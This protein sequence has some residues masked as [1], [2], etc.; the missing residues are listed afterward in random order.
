MAK[1][2]TEDSI[3]LFLEARHIESFTDALEAASPR[4]IESAAQAE[5]KNYAERFSKALSVGIAQ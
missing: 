5:K 1:K 3:R 2:K 4:P